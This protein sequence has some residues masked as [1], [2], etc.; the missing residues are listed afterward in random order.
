MTS[1][2][3]MFHIEFT[4]LVEKCTPAINHTAHVTYLI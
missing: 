2:G 3:K 4:L 1:A